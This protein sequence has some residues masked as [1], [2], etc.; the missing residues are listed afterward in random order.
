[1]HTHTHKRI[2]TVFITAEL[3]FLLFHASNVE[4]L[5]FKFIDYL[6]F[7][8][9]YNTDIVDFFLINIKYIFNYLFINGCIF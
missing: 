1:M 6:E 2:F 3:Y 7:L 4:K 8:G 5:I 9:L